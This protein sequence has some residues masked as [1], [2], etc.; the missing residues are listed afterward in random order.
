MLRSSNEKWVAWPSTSEAHG[1]RGPEANVSHSSRFRPLLRR[2]AHSNCSNQEQKERPPG[3][4]NALILEHPRAIGGSKSAPSRCFGSS[5]RRLSPRGVPS[6]NCF[7]ESLRSPILLK[8][9]SWSSG[10]LSRFDRGREFRWTDSI[11]RLVNRAGSHGQGL[12][13]AMDS[14]QDG[15]R[16]QLQP[17]SGR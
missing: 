7:G 3:K 8:S 1:E 15:R 14:E 4:G 12:C 16:P 2:F 9:R 11:C 6:G 5:A 10:S 13:F 17:S